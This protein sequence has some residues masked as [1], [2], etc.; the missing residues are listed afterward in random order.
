MMSEKMQKF[1][2]LGNFLPQTTARRL[3]I[4]TGA[5]QT[6]KT[7]L[8]QL[9]YPQLNYINLD[10]PE[11][12][13]ILRA[14]SSESWAK[15]VGNAIL[16]EAQKEPIIFEKVKYA[17]DAGHI[18][19]CL[20]LGS[21]QI[22]LLKKIRESLAGRVSIYELWPLMM[23]EIYWEG[24]SKDMPPPL[25]DRLC[26]HEDFNRILEGMPEF[27]LDRVDSRY[28]EA[29]DYLFKWG[30]MPALLPLTPEERWKWLKDYEYTYLER[31]LSDLARLD[32][33]MPFRTFQKLSALRSG[34]LLNYSE[35]A[36]DA[37]I[38]VDTAR[39]YLEY[40]RLSYQTVFLQPYY[41]N[42]T[43]SVIK[44]PKLYW[45]DVGL[46]RELSG[47]RGEFSGEIYETMVVSEL[48]KWI[49]TS[50]R[51]VEIFFYRTR[52]GLELDILLQT[53]SGIIGMEIKARKSYALT[54]IRSMKEIAGKLGRHWRGGLLIY[55]GDALKRISD[56][57]IW[58]IPS[59]RLFI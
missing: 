57:H 59:R 29:E 16:D 41:K 46:L 42:I 18:S 15:N 4:L 32:D 52:S 43:S 27:L 53:E 2:F 28:R 11:N 54:D 23:S 49:K 9:K 38:G 40:L 12:R 35:I 36:R 30:G 8:A 56:P 34:K 22:L 7:T 37:S 51:N 48:I 20:M 14:V 5:R 25:I 3:I 47:S 1:R 39:R 58:A 44:T 45:L 19:F 26:S 50:Q 13:G 21:S 10:S 31:D 24:N 33:L 55:Q 6:G 17:F